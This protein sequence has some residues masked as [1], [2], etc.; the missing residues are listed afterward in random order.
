MDAGNGALGKDGTVYGR[1]VDRPIVQLQYLPRATLF[2][3]IRSARTVLFPSLCEG[4]GLPALEAIQLGTPVI[5]S[6][7]SSLPEVVGDAGLLVN[8]YSTAEI[9]GAIKA[10]DADDT[11]LERLQTAGPAQAA[12]FTDAAWMERLRGLYAAMGLA[13]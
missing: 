9:A 7:V 5:S 2:R 10:L 3:L 1:K 13:G 8:P 11:L 4:F 6:N 12:R